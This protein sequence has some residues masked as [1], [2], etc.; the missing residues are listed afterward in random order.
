MRPFGYPCP[1][2]KGRLEL[3]HER[4]D[5]AR[6]AGAS[7]GLRRLRLHRGAAGGHRG[8]LGRPAPVAGVL[9]EILIGWDSRKWWKVF[10]VVVPRG[11]RGLRYLRA[12]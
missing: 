1:E 10:A 2:C 3:R 4:P 8:R 12:L 11:E 6:A 5:P 9:T 7:N